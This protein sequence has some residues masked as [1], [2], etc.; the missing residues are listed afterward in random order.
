MSQSFFYRFTG[1]LVLIVMISLG[2]I[3]LEKRNLEY[4]RALTQQQF[5]L[6]VLLEK[7]AS[8]RLRTQQLGA[9]TRLIDALEAGR[10]T[11]ADS[12]PTGTPAQ[13]V[14]SSKKASRKKKPAR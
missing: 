4:R 13:P 1:A 6:D 8:L 7:R 14:K 12:A 9:P 5:R 10:V 3:A 11:V 2:G